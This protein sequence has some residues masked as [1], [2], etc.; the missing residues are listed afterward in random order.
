MNAL[1]PRLLDRLACLLPR[2]LF[3][4]LRLVDHVIAPV[5]GALRAI[6]SL[7]ALPLVGP[8]LAPVY[9]LLLVI[10]GL[11]AFLLAVA[12]L[13]GSTL[14]YIG[15]AYSAVQVSHALALISLLRHL[16]GLA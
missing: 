11:G 16:L 2:D 3:A 14:L 6:G 10:G 5:D 4:A 8:A 9:A 13:L 1:L 15:A 12:L 7:L